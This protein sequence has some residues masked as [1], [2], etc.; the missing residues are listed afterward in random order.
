MW[1]FSKNEIGK[2]KN[3]PLN[4]LLH[5]TKE[6]CSLIECIRH[7]DSISYPLWVWQHVVLRCQQWAMT[8]QHHILQYSQLVLWLLLIVNKRSNPW[9]LFWNFAHIS[10]KNWTSVELHK[11]NVP[12]YLLQLFVWCLLAS[13]M[14]TLSSC[15]SSNSYYSLFH[16]LVTKKTKKTVNYFINEGGIYYVTLIVS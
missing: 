10:Y 12:I 13:S 1:K 4:V 14:A 3:S 6:S 9:L 11:F 5:L 8:W 7:S 2:L 15:L 16:Q